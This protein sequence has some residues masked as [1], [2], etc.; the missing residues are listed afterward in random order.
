[1][2]LYLFIVIIFIAIFIMLLLSFVLNLLFCLKL[3]LSLF[4]VIF[5]TS[6]LTLTYAC[7]RCVHDEWCVYILH[8]NLLTHVTPSLLYVIL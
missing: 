3:T 2:V 1:M 6:Y 7:S 8:V 5:H 4:T